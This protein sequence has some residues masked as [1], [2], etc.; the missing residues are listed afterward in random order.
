[1]KNHSTTA[2]HIENSAPFSSIRSLFDAGYT[3]RSNA[4]SNSLHDSVKSAYLR[5]QIAAHDI[6]YHTSINDLTS[7]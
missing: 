3:R 6:V 1:L 7:P 2:K 5:L 4:N